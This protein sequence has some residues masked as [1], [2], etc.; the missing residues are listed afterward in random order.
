MFR[1]I[2]LQLAC[3]LS[4]SISIPALAQDSF[5]IESLGTLGGNFSVST[6]I[7]ASGHVSGV[8]QT[9]R[10]ENHAF[11]F[12][13][14]NKLI[15]IGTL[16][17]TSS[18]PTA[19]NDFNQ[20][21]GFSS[22]E[23]GANRAFLWEAGTMIG[24]DD[25]GAST[26]RAV[27]INNSGEVAITTTS[28]A[29]GQAR[30]IYWSVATG[31]IDI[32]DLGGGSATPSAINASGVVVGTSFDA[33]SAKRAFSW[34]RDE[35][36]KDLGP[37]TEVTD[38]NDSD[39]LCGINAGIPF[40]VTTAGRTDLPLL[41]GGTGRANAINNN[42]EL[43]GFATTATGV[44]AVKWRADGT[45]VDAGALGGNFAIF[46]DIND[47][48]TAVGSGVEN[49]TERAI[50]WNESDGVLVDLGVLAG[51]TGAEAV[52]INEFDQIAGEAFDAT[53]TLAVRWTVAGLAAEL[54]A[55]IEDIIESIATLEAD[56]RL[57]NGEA[58]ELTQKLEGAIDALEKDNFLAAAN[59]LNSVLNALDS[60]NIDSVVA[61]ELVPL[62][63]IVLAEF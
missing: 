48:G 63:L 40:V 35:G 3:L 21:V 26:S 22:D 37:A 33:A 23:T 30:A 7:N 18:S 47:N 60:S 49:F 36:M 14:G 5:E 52:A 58:N 17:G 13:G 1:P 4:I 44:H 2:I 10:G 45:L 12:D 27:D 32:G 6:D 16:G 15:D 42:G 34:N 41:V 57:T 61:D 25:L 59:K 62:V 43:A 31:A 29:F 50:A 39:D 46:V 53:G 19:I 38:V 8:A 9:N 24:L 51:G 20:V 11:L 55:Q 54:I 28:G 56:G